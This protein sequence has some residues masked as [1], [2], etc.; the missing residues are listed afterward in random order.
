MDHN[1]HYDIH[2]MITETNAVSFRQ[3]L[4][5]MINQVQYQ[6][7]SIVIHKDGKPAAVLIDAELFTR[8]RR[9]R[10]RFNE[11]SGRIA[12]A[13]RD[14]SPELGMAEIDAAVDRERRS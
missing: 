8:I 1:D 3:N 13:Y 9:M 7:S 6:N 5:E 10:D 11:L 14:V 4:G 2:H 12:E